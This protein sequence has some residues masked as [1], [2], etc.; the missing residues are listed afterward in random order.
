MSAD[1]D[2]PAA[3]A[4]DAGLRLIAEEH[5]EG[6]AGRIVLCV[7]KVDSVDADP[8]HEELRQVLGIARA[9]VARG[10]GVRI[11]PHERWHRR[12]T[13]PDAV[14]VLSADFDPGVVASA[15]P[16]IAWVREE[17]PAW[18]GSAR[19]GSYDAVLA[20]SALGLAEVEEHFRGPTGLLP[21]GVDSR[22]FSTPGDRTAVV[23]EMLSPMAIRFG[24][25][26]GRVLEALAGGALPAVN[27]GLGLAAAGLGGL[28]VFRDPDELQTV[29]SWALDDPEAAASRAGRLRDVVLQRHTF[30]Q[31]A[32]EL[33]QFLPQARDNAARARVTL[34]F[35][36]DYVDNPYQRLLYADLEPAGIRVMTPAEVE[37]VPRDPGG[38]L[39]N[40]ILHVHWTAPILQFQPGPLHAYR[41]LEKFRAGIRN[42]KTRGGTL[43]WTVHNVL[44]HDGRHLTLEIE[45]HRFLADAADVIHVLGAETAEAAEP[46]YHLPAEKVRV[47]EHCTYASVYP[48]WIGRAEARR[49]LGVLDE[50]IALLLLGQIRPYKGLDTLLTAFDDALATDPRLRLLVAGRPS[51]HGSLQPWLDVCKAHPR[52]TA[53]FGFVPDAEL[54]VWLRAA[55]IMVLPYHTTLN[56][57]ALYLAQGFGVP[58]VAP[59]T[60]VVGAKLDPGHAMGFVPGDVASLAT[61]IRAASRTLRAADARESARRAAERNDPSVMSAAFLDLVRDLIP[62]ARSGAPSPGLPT[63]GPGQ[64]S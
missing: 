22:L 60:G 3:A 5:A 46:L 54:Q 53:A 57:G 52:V 25:V 16:L 50:E 20:S 26:S 58:F 18:V 23:A 48:D 13:D 1:P 34:A 37:R 12:I 31:R 41:R 42:Y 21:D 8:G 15:V 32:E 51:K 17:V 47:I 2:V 45:L 35:F 39:R 4:Q 63:P 14:I 9:L 33:L 43:V 55:D 11:V 6:P 28:P 64:R 24:H 36:P 44:P 27:S 49:R 10:W 38:D 56:S 62:A 29:V 19:L 40:R 59:A 30:D 7:D 61:A